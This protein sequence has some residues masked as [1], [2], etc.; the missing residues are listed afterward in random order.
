MMEL[1]RKGWL[2]ILS[3]LA[4]EREDLVNSTKLTRC[5]SSRRKVR[6]PLGA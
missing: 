1:L 6:S 3:A 2:Q 4:M 5:K